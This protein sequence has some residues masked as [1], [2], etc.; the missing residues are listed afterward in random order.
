MP[1]KISLT[2]LRKLVFERAGYCCEYCLI[3]MACSI[4]P[5]AVEHI[6]PKSEGGSNDL[7]NLACSCGGCNGHKYNKR[8]APDP[9]NNDMVALFNPREH[10]WI[11]H[12]TWSNDFQRLIGISPTGRA[13]IEA[14]QLNRTGVVKVRKLLLLAGEHPPVKL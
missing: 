10:P 11:D 13:T 14:L 2:A 7:N 4:Q 8:K 1:N 5:Y 9:A 6:I 3:P 12:F